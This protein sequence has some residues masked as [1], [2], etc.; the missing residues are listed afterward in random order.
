M[1]EQTSS[2]LAFDDSQYIDITAEYQSKSS[3]QITHW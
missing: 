3:M 2:S 1:N